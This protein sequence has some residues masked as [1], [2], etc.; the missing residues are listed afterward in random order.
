MGWFK[1]RKSLDNRALEACM[2]ALAQGESVEKRSAFYAALRAST[3]LIATPGMEPDAREKTAEG[4]Q[5]IRF[6]ATTDLDGKSAMLAFT[7][8]AALLAWRP[9]GCVYT[10]L[11]ARDVFNLALKGPA[12]H[13]LINVSGPVGG[14]IE[15]HEIHAL[16]EGLDPIEGVQRLAP[17]TKIEIEP[18]AAPLPALVDA[19]RAGAGAAP[20]IRA[21]Y[22]VTATIGSGEPG[23][24]VGMELVPGASA[25]DAVRALQQVVQPLLDQGRGLAFLPLEDDPL[26]ESIRTRG[27]RV[28]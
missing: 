19:L 21:L 23:S 11:S 22:L 26:G 27:L 12:D 8:E 7:S 1:R 18:P 24:L 16:A 20:S 14:R 3:L 28:M 25:E 5:Q 6:I 2:R 15:R 10:A 4:P 9:V 13:I 17:G